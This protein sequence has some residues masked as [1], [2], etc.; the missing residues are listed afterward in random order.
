[1][2]NYELP[3][4]FQ[5]AIRRAMDV[6]LSP[7]V[8]EALAAAARVELPRAYLEIAAEAQRTLESWRRSVASVV[9]PAVEQWRLQLTD[10]EALTRAYAPIIESFQKTY[11]AAIPDL[12]RTV[13]E[14]WERA[15]P[16]NWVDLEAAE[17]M[18]TVDVI[19][20]T[21][22]T[23]VWLPRVEIVRKI[24]AADASD[25]AA[26]LI[27]HRDEVLD[28]AAS[29]LAEVVDADLQLTRT[30]IERAIAAFQDGHQWAAQALASSAF[31]SECHTL[32]EHGLNSI[33][34]QMAD[35]DQEDATIDQMRLRT[36][37]VAGAKALATYDPER[38]PQGLAEFN[39][40]NSAHR[41]TAA[42]WNEANALSAIMLA[43]AFL[44]EI[45]HWYA[46]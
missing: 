9:A 1:V 17:V 12:A 22:F 2:D 34:R 41:I 44:R 36:I 16:S 14:A 23:L 45:Q 31:T 26:L 40:H 11:G 24:L 19:R 42:Q 46:V 30:A 28:D 5:D 10:V 33:R 7:G 35:E 25:V 4:H 13:R 38:D 32:L 6:Q 3:Q 39:R 27:E 20:A 37:F 29:C 15:M 43:T 21:G 8:R 18:A